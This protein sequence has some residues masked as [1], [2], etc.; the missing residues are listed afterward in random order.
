MEQMT[1]P[2]QT[3]KYLIIS[4]LTTREFWMLVICLLLILNCLWMAYTNKSNIDNSV[5]AVEGYYKHNCICSVNT[6]ENY[7]SIKVPVY[8]KDIYNINVNY[9]DGE[10]SQYDNANINQY[11]KRNG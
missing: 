4:N 10:E 9:T 3:K 8:D 7:S 1:K 2:I 5:V 6:F 11:T